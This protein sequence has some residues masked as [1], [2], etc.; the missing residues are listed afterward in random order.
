M[1]NLLGAIKKDGRRA[2]HDVFLDF[3]QAVP[4]P[5][6]QDTYAK[7]KAV[8]D[9]VDDIISRLQE[10]NGAGEKIRQAISSPS[11]E[12]QAEAWE[13]LI[14]LVG[15]LKHFYQF[16]AEIEQVLPLLL[17]ALCSE[18]P[19]ETLD[20]KQALAKQF[21]EVLQFVLKFDDLK[22]NSPAI[23]NDFS[24]YRRTLSRKKMKN[25]DDDE[26]IV[27]HEEANRMS[28]FYAYPTPMLKAISDATTRFVTDNKSIPLEYTTDC[29]S[30]MAGVCKAMIE[31]PSFSERFADPN[32]VLFCQRVMVALIVLYDRVHV[33]GAFSRKNPA[34][35]VAGSI[36]V[37]R[38]QNSPAMDGLLN[39]LRYSTVH[40]NDEDTPVAV[41]KLLQ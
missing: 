4:T 28:L 22:M 8:L 40:L 27:S 18:N 33:L 31:T 15:Q 11:E 38:A 37:L 36:K 41:K 35:D 13:A 14:P 30:T 26:T 7:V 32:T 21:A 6:E 10:Y 24:Y 34:I 23:Q 19:L 5:D 1:G 25:D 39:A 29:L 20:A 12:T 3:E 9:Q 17:E 2:D 16:S